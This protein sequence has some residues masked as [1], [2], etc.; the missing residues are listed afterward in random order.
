MQV[1]DHHTTENRKPTLVL[2]VPDGIGVRNYLF[3]D[4]LKYLQQAGI[5]LV[6]LHRLAPSVVAQVAQLHPDTFNTV[7]LPD[8]AESRSADLLR[9]LCMFIRMHRNAKTLNNKSIADN[10]FF[11]STQ[12][13]RKKIL[14]Q[15]MNMLAGLLAKVAWMSDMSEAWLRRKMLN[16]DAGKSYASLL[17]QLKPDMILCTHQRSI[18]AGYAMS[19]ANTLGI[20]TCSVVFSW[21]N[22]PKTRMT[23]EAK[24]WL[25]WSNWMKEE[26][27]LLYPKINTANIHVTGTPQFDAYY[28]TALYWTKE[29]FHE[30]FGTHGKKHVFC[31]SGNEPSFPSDH[32]YLSDV[33]MQL[34]KLAEAKDCVVLV[35]PS[36]NDY[37]GRL[38][39]VVERFPDLAIVARPLW[40]RE[41]NRDWETNIPT[42]EDEAVLVN[43]VLHCDAL[44]NIGSTMN[45]DF[46]HHNKPA[47][48][49]AYNHPDC[50]GF[51]ITQGYLQEHLKTWDGLNAVVMLHKKDDLNS[52]LPQLISA[53]HVLAPDK[54]RWKKIITDDIYPASEKLA[55]CVLKLMQQRT[56]TS[57]FK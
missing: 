5:Q 35:R 38:E 8:I 16:D 26:F 41:G 53:P 40:K 1:A 47:I 18:E 13:G 4:V 49:F 23:Y 30:C 44:F 37:S 51:D 3:T 36:P 10:W 42:P 20:H 45:L 9:R 54:L 2:L 6:L 15:L 22:L 52:L 55:K 27:C 29:R 25:V 34:S 14:F 39:A 48:N 57:L 28:N 19:V 46:A 43:L 11:F 33:L 50:P 7:Y 56:T 12:K 32:L 31:F 17:Q 21:D 24:D